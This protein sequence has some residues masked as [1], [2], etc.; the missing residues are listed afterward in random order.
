MMMVFPQSRIPSIAP[1]TETVLAE[2]GSPSLDTGVTLLVVDDDA[3]VR[4]ALEILAWS[5]GW[6]CITFPGARAFFDAF[7]TY[8]S[9]ASCLI[10]DLHMPGGS[11]AAVAQRLRAEGETLPIIVVTAETQPH[12]LEEV[13]RH[14]VWT[15]LGKPFSAEEFSRAV[16]SCLTTR[17]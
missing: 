6:N 5:Y 10:L 3:A 9:I 12:K 8:R 16:E 15:I 2:H 13:T 4:E 1:S 14:G 17:D 11:G 7:P